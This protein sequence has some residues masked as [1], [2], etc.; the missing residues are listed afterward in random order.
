MTGV[1]T[2]ADKPEKKYAVDVL[3]STKNIETNRTGL[4]HL[5]F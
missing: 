4:V 1:V 3:L 5:P 2:L